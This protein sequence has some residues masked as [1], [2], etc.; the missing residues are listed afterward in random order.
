MAQRLNGLAGTPQLTVSPSCTYTITEYGQYI[1]AKKK[2]GD[3]GVV[4][5]TKTPID[6]HADAMDATRYA[7]SGL[8]TTVPRKPVVMAGRKFR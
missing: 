2:E 5:F 8:G 1:W 6:H 7:V 3:T 4:Y